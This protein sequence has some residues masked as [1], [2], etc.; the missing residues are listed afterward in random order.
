MGLF[1]YLVLPKDGPINDTWFV[2]NKNK[3]LADLKDYYEAC[4][5][6]CGEDDDINT[7]PAKE[8]Y[9][10]ANIDIILCKGEIESFYTESEYWE[11]FIEEESARLEKEHREHNEMFLAGIK[12]GM[13]FVQGK[14]KRHKTDKIPWQFKVIK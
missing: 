1:N 4:I 7:I 14:A 5:D 2:E 13:E 9:E 8:L 12:T 10:K 6:L 11:K 3:I